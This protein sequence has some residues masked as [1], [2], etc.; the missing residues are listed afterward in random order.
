MELRKDPIT[1]SWVIVG[2]EEGSSRPLEGCPFCPGSPCQP[3]VIST[4]PASE[5]GGGPVM[6][7]V[8]PSPLYRI[9]GEPQRRSE[10]IYDVMNTVGAHEVLVQSIRHDI[11]LWQ[12]SDAE[13]SQFLLMAANRIHDLKQDLRFKYVTLFKNYGAL[14]GQ[15]FDHPV[16]QITATTFVP[17]RVLY[18]LRAS[19]DYYLEKERCVFCDSLSQEMRTPIRIVEATN[20]YVALC[21]FASRVPFEVW[22]MPRKHDSSFERTVTSKSGNI[23]ELSSMLRRT[24]QRVIAISDSFHLVLH[25][26]PNTY[27]KSNILQYW[28]TVD[29]DY[30]WHIEILPVVGARAKP[31]FLKEVYYSPISSEAAAERLKTLRVR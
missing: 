26:V 30:H 15:E 29:E 24:L 31:Y 9:E 5:S 3:Q 25:S 8:H 22:I 21:P 16:S 18:E 20:G 6:A 28:K 23:A 10:G 12:S 14:S 11:E 17:R 19:R 27:Q 13:I 1:R 7:V 4:L 2:S